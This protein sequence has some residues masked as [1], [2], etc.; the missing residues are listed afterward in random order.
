VNGVAA[1]IRLKRVDTSK[2]PLVSRGFHWINE[3]PLNR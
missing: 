1:T 3:R 2:A